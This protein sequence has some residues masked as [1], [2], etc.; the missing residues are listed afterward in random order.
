MP[1]LL[2]AL[3]DNLNGVGQA[4]DGLD[5]PEDPEDEPGGGGSILPAAAKAAGVLAGGKALQGG[6][7]KAVGEIGGRRAVVINEGESGIERLAASAASIAL[8]GLPVGK[9]TAA[10]GSK[11]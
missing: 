1:D 11:L 2:D 3:T 5:L 10:V 4:P 6:D 7:Q 8:L 9:I